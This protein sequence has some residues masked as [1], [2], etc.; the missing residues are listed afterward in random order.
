LRVAEADIAVAISGIAGPGGGSPEKPVG[1]VWFAWGLATGARAT[2]F[3]QFA[4]DRL[5]VQA[6]SVESALAGLV[7]LLRTSQKTTV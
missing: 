3:E 6:Q 2:R 7:E 5:A 4:G 1:S